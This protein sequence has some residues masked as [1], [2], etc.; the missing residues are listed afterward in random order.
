[1]KARDRID[2]TETQEILTAARKA[3]CEGHARDWLASASPASWE[4]R[5]AARLFACAHFLKK[6]REGLTFDLSG[7]L[8]VRFAIADADG[9]LRDR[10]EQ[11]VLI[12]TLQQPLEQALILISTGAHEF[13][14]EVTDELVEV[15]L[16]AQLENVRTPAGFLPFCAAASKASV[17]RE[18][19]RLVPP[20]KPICALLFAI[21][22]EMHLRLEDDGTFMIPMSTAV[23]KVLGVG[24]TNVHRLINK[25]VKLEILE[26]ADSYYSFAKGIGKKYRLIKTIDE[27]LADR[28]DTSSQ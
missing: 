4:I 16:L 17:A 5:A 9:D 23:A 2:P 10:F 21:C 6:H 19:K 24:R 13:E 22:Q 1:M 15:E 20:L 8:L 14:C 7:F 3:S 11:P 26:V 27:Y 18:A 28:S 25:L 12:E